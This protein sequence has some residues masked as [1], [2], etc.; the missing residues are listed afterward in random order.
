MNL[1]QRLLAFLTH[2]RPQQS[3]SQLT[4]EAHPQQAVPSTSIFHGVG[5]LTIFGGTFLVIG[6][7]ICW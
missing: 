4:Q 1:L 7:C 3:A 5:T 6:R 2:R